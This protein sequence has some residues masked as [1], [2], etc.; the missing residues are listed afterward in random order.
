MASTAYRDSIKAREIEKLRL[1]QMAGDWDEIKNGTI[2]V[3]A[4]IRI[5]QGQFEDMLA[6]V[7]KQKGREVSFKVFGTN[8]YGS[9]NNTHVRAA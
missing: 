1:R 7:V 6:T 4:R 2:L 3:G 9:I 8:T 5:M